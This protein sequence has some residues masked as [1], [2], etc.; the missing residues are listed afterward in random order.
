MLVP[1]TQPNTRNVGH[2][3]YDQCL[4]QFQMQRQEQ[5]SILSGRQKNLVLYMA[6]YS[7]D[8]DFENSIAI[9]SEIRRLQEQIELQALRRKRVW[10]SLFNLNALSDLQC[11]EQYRFRRNDFGLI[12]G[13]IP[14]EEGLDSDG[15]MRTSQKRYLVDPLES[16]AM[17]MRRLATPIR[18]IDI[19][20]EFGKH[21]SALS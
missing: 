7:G 11:L 12:A 17:L 13:L 18:W 8:D 3:L 1:K 10:A 5:R 19:Q 21:R 4:A 2:C 16:N 9:A 14:W 20:M 15:R 6:I